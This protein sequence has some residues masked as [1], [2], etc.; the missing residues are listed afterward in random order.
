MS[1]VQTVTRNA[2]LS[3]VPGETP[4][5][6][7]ISQLPPGKKTSRGS[8]LTNCPSHNDRNPSL[9]VWENLDG[10]TG[11]KCYAGC[12]TEQVLA[13]IG[14]K[15]CDLFPAR[16][17]RA[18]SN[19]P[20]RRIVN[21]YDYHD[22]NGNLLFQTVRY[23]PKGF[24]QR[25]P[26]GKG[27][28]I[29]NMEGIEPVPYGLP[30]L[31]RAVKSGETIFI[32]EGEKDCDN[33]AAL[34]LTAT[35]NAMGAGKWR[36][37]Y[38]QYFAGAKVIILPDNDEVGRKHAEQVASSLHGVAKSVKVLELPGLPHK[39]DISDWLQAGHTKEELLVLIEQ[40]PEWQPTEQSQGSL[41]NSSQT[42]TADVLGG[43]INQTDLGNARRLVN[44]H[45][46]DLRY[47]HPWNKWL[48]WDGMRWKPDD[49]GEVERRAKETVRLIYAEASSESDER[50]REELVKWALRSEN[51][52][53]IRAMI[54]LSESEPGIPVSPGEMDCDPWLL[55]CQNGTLDLRTG[56]LQPHNQADLI[57][58]LAP[59][60]YD[61][62]AKC[63]AWLDF[64]DTIFDGNGDLISFVQRAVGYSLTGH[65]DERC[66]FT[67]WGNGKNGKSTFLE[68]I[69]VMLGDYA[70]KVPTETLLT[71]RNAT[72]PNDVAKLRG[73]RFVRASESEQGRWL[74]EAKIKE[75]TGQDT[76]TAR[77]L[78]AEWFDFIPEFKIWLGTNHKPVI[79]GTDQAIWDRIRLIP[80]T[81]RI[82]NPKPRREIDA[83]FHQEMPGILSWAVQGC[84]AWQKDGLGMPDEVRQATDEYRREMDSIA[85]FIDEC[86]YIREDLSVSSGEL[87]EAFAAWAEATGG[88][89]VG[90]EIPSSNYFGRRLTEHGF[91][92]F[93]G[94]GGVWRR[95]GVTLLA[96]GFSEDE[97]F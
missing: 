6:K 26:D 38:N 30:G 79:R 78:H 89:A 47:C 55:N 43:Q 75:L 84:L 13:A 97:P 44:K 66:M 48:A 42:S 18:A 10:S 17:G 32:P 20:R 11:L 62:L 1:S 93:R 25:R 3:N 37:T 76:V 34:G 71:T 29:W 5:R 68:T 41:D 60:L 70:D 92:A 53:R 46:E 24:N 14:L 67:L 64:L 9:E 22:E 58:K 2:S 12:S 73:A 8:I 33:L 16:P 65:T 95:Q 40:A 82:Q 23:L 61:P 27:G 56:A 21:V 15:K 85:R 63:P 74:A 35:T 91:K 4:F 31:I 7:I 52:Q 19:K 94:T 28:Y 57:T 72:I 81:V 88:E 96:H 54:S 51:Q 50:L 83:A 77:F 87:Y 36:G 45:G 59:V 90:A 80:F 39:G 49:S 86:C 69:G